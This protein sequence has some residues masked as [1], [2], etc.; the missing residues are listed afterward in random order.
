[1]VIRSPKQ[2]Y[3]VLHRKQGAE[4]FDVLICQDEREEADTRYTILQFFR[5]EEIRW[6]LEQDLPEQEP[7][8]DFVDYRESFIFNDSLMMVF[9]RR[10]GVKLEEWMKKDS[11]SLSRRMEIGRRLLERLLMLNMPGYLLCSILNAQ[12]I[13]VTEASEVEIRYEPAAVIFEDRNPGELLAECFLRIFLF[14]FHEEEEGQLNTEIHSFIEQLRREP[15]EDIFPIYQ[16]YVHM[17]ENQEKCRDIPQKPG[18]LR[19]RLDERKNK[20]QDSLKGYVKLGRY[21]VAVRLMVLVICVVILLAFFSVFFIRPFLTAKFFTRTMVVD[22]FERFDY[23]GRV[24]LIDKETETVLFT[25]RLEEGKMEGE[26]TLYDEE[27]NCIYQ[28]EFQNNQYEGAGTAYYKNG[29]VQYAGN[30]S[31]GKM[32]GQGREHYKNGVLKYRGQ[33]AQGIYEGSGKLYYKSGVLK[34]EGGFAQ[35]IYEGT[36]R[37]NYKNGVLKYCGEFAQGIYEGSGKLYYKDG[38]L[39]YDGGFAQGLFEGDGEYYDEDGVLRHQGKFAAGSRQ[40]EGKSYDSQGEIC[41]EGNFVEDRMEGKGKLYQ[42]GKL[43]YEGEF[44]AGKQ[45]G[46]G[47]QYEKKTGR[48]IYDG[49]F[50]KGKYEGPGKLFDGKAGHLIYEGE[51]YDGIFHG[52]GKL[53]DEETQLLLYEGEFRLGLYDGEGVLY[54]TEGGKLYEGQ[55]RLGKYHGQGKLYEPETGEMMI[56]GEFRNGAPL[57]PEEGSSYG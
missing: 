18:T 37:L 50:V 57:M 20:K 8:G 43:V 16:R 40:G 44:Q 35:G 25:G 15:C 14:L 31:G 1:M 56:E 10:E 46:E 17:Q 24:R 42:K 53:F 39:G 52:A 27:G 38:V 23:S 51:F 33:F 36:G 9:L 5:K 41:Y 34:Y 7:A 32:D 21:Y 54:G 49:T 13:L 3:K 48:L 55:F 26:G 28:G 30:F 22:S 29:V 6:L 12:C 11:P 47:K 45:C 19:Q 2:E 4:Y